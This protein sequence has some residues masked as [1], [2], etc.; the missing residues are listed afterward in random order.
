M[1]PIVPVDKS[2]RLWDFPDIQKWQVI[3]SRANFWPEMAKINAQHQYERYSVYS[4]YWYKITDTDAEGEQRA[5]QLAR[6]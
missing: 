4:L 6:A 1:P 2:T 5:L 3:Q